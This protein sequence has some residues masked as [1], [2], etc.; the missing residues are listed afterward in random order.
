MNTQ[1]F[2]KVT[3]TKQLLS[4]MAVRSPVSPCQATGGKQS[5]SFFLGT[6]LELGTPLMG[7]LCAG[8]AGV[9]RQVLGMTTGCWDAR[10]VPG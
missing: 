1:D 10:R 9:K 7:H 5:L 4:L 8:L 2:C 3:H 6:W